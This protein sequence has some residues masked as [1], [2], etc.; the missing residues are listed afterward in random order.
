MHS[1]EGVKNEN[2][3]WVLKITIY[4]ITWFTRINVTHINIGKKKQFKIYKEIIIGKSIPKQKL[5][6]MCLTHLRICLL[7]S[8]Y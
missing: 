6:E 5:E 7:I 1:V 3:T 2:I 4:K 8:T